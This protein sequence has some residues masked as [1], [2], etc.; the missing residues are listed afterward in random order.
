MERLYRG[1]TLRRALH[2]ELPVLPEVE[3]LAA[4]QFRQSPHPDAAELPVQSL[5]QLHEH[6]QRGGVWVAVT[7]EGTVA[8]FAICKPVD[9]D[10]FIV[11]ADVHPTHSRRGLG[12][13]LFD[14]LG[15]WARAEGYPALLLTTFR[16]V[17]WNAPYYERLGFRVLREEQQ[18][19][20][21]RGIRAQETEFG[22]PPESRVC[23]RRI[24][25]AGTPR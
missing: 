22:L 14:F 18:G 21:L 25:D 23:M 7:R 20:G 11:E 3:R 16:D 9:G 19:P 24:L 5:E 4:Q 17:A 1:Y 2:G 13:A 10:L 8:A 6:Q 15:E 12:A